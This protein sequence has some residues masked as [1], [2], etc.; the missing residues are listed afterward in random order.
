MSLP[1]SALTMAANH[2]L[3]NVVKAELRKLVHE[4]E[5]AFRDRVRLLTADFQITDSHRLVLVRVSGVV[6]FSDLTQKK[7]KAVKKQVRG[8][9][10]GVSGSGGFKRSILLSE[11]ES[12]FLERF[13]AEAEANLCPVKKT[14][15]AAPA[16]WTQRSD[17]NDG[18]NSAVTKLLDRR[19][20]MLQNTLW[21]PKSDAFDAKARERFLALEF[22]NAQ[23]LPHQYEMVAVCPACYIIYHVID[24]ERFERRRATARAAAQKTTVLLRSNFLASERAAISTSHGTRGASNGLAHV[25][26]AW[27]EKDGS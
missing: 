26:S 25:R 5:L 2:Q 24:A 14:M 6:F 11:S 8:A 10:Y 17:G 27:D 1:P 12:A 4:V 22:E 15:I 20:F 16:S 19:I 13:G 21:N 7:K 18:Q 3:E 23:W 9:V